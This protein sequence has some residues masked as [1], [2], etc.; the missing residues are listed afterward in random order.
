MASVTVWNRLEPSP[1]ENSLAEGMAARV[2]DPLWMLTRQWQLG[3]F[4]GED[5]GTPAVVEIAGTFI[6]LDAHEIGGRPAALPAGPWEAA[7]L[8]EAR[9]LE[10]SDRVELGQAFELL[11]ADAL[12]GASQSTLATVLAAFRAAFPL[13][14]AAADPR[15]PAGAEL[16]MVCAGRV[17]DGAALLGRLRGSPPEI[18]AGVNMPA[19]AAAAVRTALTRL[20]DWAAAVVGQ[21]GSDDAPA[22]RPERLDYATRLLGGPSA[23]AAAGDPPAAAG[24]VSAA[25]GNVPA[26]PGSALVIDLRPRPSGEIDWFSC[27]LAAGAASGAG[28]GTPFRRAVLPARIRFAGMPTDSFWAFETSTTDFADLRPED[29][30]LA[31]LI[32]ADFVMLHGDD[33]F[34]APLDQPVGTACDLTL[35]VTHDVFGVMRSVERPSAPGAGARAPWSVFTPSRGAPGANRPLIIPAV[36]GPAVMTGEAVEEVR[37]VRDEPAQLVWAIER[38]LPGAAGGGAREEDQDQAG[39]SLGAAAAA[40]AERYRIASYVPANWIPL[41][42]TAVAASGTTDV[43]LERA[44]LLGGPPDR[45]EPIVPSGRIL[46]PSAL[47]AT[48]YRIHDEEIGRTGVRVTRVVQRSRWSD[49]R[50]HLWISRVRHDA[51]TEPA[52][53]LRFDHLEA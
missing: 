12:T 22:W 25:A 28:P 38:T 52:S 26:A 48:P 19:G 39:S 44:A 32:V 14:A 7:I 11:L 4:T 17:V 8:G 33:W 5:A 2:R 9:E 18:P 30:D 23:P 43:A 13:V 46:R 51:A 40:G 49:G 20:I 42:P 35:V 24:N 1:R 6:G 45:R 53:T 31:K 10:P 36:A 50:A 41:V 29:G 34:V 21:V 47:A 3:E 16:L 15:D 37:F 27:D